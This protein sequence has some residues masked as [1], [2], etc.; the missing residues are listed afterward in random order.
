[1]LLLP[2]YTYIYVPDKS[3]YPRSLAF[4]Y[5]CKGHIYVSAIIIL[6]LDLSDARI[7]IILLLVLLS[8]DFFV[9]PYARL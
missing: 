6:E 9:L 2:G 1:M 7:D 4:I 5:T 8:R 3:I